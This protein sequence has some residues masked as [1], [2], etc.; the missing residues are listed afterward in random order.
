M[1]IPY[2]PKTIL[3][4]LVIAV[5]IPIISYFFFLQLEHIIHNDLYN[6]GLSYSTNW[7]DL[8]QLYAY[9]YL[10]SQ[11]SSWFFFSGSIISFLGYNAKKTNRWRS[12]CVLLI[13]LGTISSVL[14][15]LVFFQL[16]TLVNYDLYLYG[17]QFSVEWYSNYLITLRIMFLLTSLLSI[18]ALAAAVLFYSSTR[19]KR[20]LP[21]R[22]FD[23]ILIGIGTVLL[24]MSIVYSSSILALLGLGLLFWGVIFTYVTTSEYVQK[25]LLDTTL[26]AHQ[27]TLNS[28]IQKLEYGGDTIYLPP[29]FFNTTNIYKAYISKD[30]LKK[31]PTAK[32]MPKQ[33]PDFLIAR[34]PKP[35][36]VLVT[37]P[38]VELAQLFEK[39]IEKDFITTSL[40]DLQLHL[41]KVLIDELEVT[42]YF[43]MEI[44]NDLIHVTIDDSHFRIPEA[45]TELSSLYFYFNSPLV[46]AFACIL[47]K[48]TGMPIT[49]MKS[50]TDKKSN[51]V[52][53]DYCILKTEL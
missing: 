44:E 26:K 27:K 34:I 30:K 6:Y 21:A 32:M 24:A 18:F 11:T 14:N 39:T 28:I 41:P 48:A 40:Q 47:A 8:Y 3:A 36:A 5:V 20:R 2:K 42:P 22:L 1:P 23:S 50:K 29:Q 13:A 19:E 10:I 46:C 7:T 33:K 12:A 4:I 15:F 49:I 9:L 16:D 52:T 43:D 51:V 25:V 38:G 35:Q 53:V 17:L 37:P 45:E 31:V